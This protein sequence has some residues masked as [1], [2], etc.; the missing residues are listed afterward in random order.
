MMSQSSRTLHQWYL[1]ERTRTLCR[2]DNQVVAALMYGSFL[3][4]EGD[5]FSDI[6]FWIFVADDRLA[7][8]SIEL[9]INQI[10]PTILIVVNEFGTQVAVFTSLV[11]GEFHFVP[12]STMARVRTWGGISVQAEEMIVVDRTD[13]LIEHLRSLDGHTPV[14]PLDRVG[15][16]IGR[17]LNWFLLGLNVLER[18]EIA[19]AQAI[20]AEVD[21]YLLWLVRLDERVT[22]HWLTP[23][24]NLESDVSAAARAR[25]VRCTA[26]AQRLP[27]IAAYT[28]AWQWG[29]QLLSS[30]AQRHGFVLPDELL[31]ALDT[32]ARSLV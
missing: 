2:R 14:P 7:Q 9:W 11:R 19:R 18:G 4:G 8:L 25:Y 3:T 17:Y 29:R 20:L 1:I 10:E 26:P 30:L 22:V 32:R 21:T 16:L 27:L 23:S 15:D 5:R 13:E 28:E 6:E 24:R 12:A 31:N